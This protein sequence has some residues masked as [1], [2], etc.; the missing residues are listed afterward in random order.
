MGQT[1]RDAVNHWTGLI[2]TITL[3]K[4]EFTATQLWADYFRLEPNRGWIQH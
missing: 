1:L 2:G 3:F 4:G